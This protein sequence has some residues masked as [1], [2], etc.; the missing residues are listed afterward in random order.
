MLKLKFR[1]R[2]GASRVTEMG[3]A[4]V[5]R[6]STHPWFYT[7][8]PRVCETRRLVCSDGIGALNGSKGSMLA[9]QEARRKKRG[10]GRA[11]VDG[12]PSAHHP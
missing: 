4:R 10:L 2:K 3:R 7:T 12:C 5:G 6:S 1:E 9:C 8:A 11:R